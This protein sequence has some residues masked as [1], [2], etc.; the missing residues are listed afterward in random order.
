MT[1]LTDSNLHLHLR[2]QDNKT[3]HGMEMLR[4][5][6]REMEKMMEKTMEEGE[7]QCQIQNQEERPALHAGLLPHGR[8]RPKGRELMP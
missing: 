3:C 6:G 8:G 4:R 7:D 1:Q 2:L 5:R